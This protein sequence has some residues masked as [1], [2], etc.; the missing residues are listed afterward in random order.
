MPSCHSPPAADSGAPSNQVPVCTISFRL[1]ASPAVQLAVKYEWLQSAEHR[2]NGCGSVQKI[3]IAE[4]V[5]EQSFR[6]Q[7]HVLEQAWVPRDHRIQRI[8]FVDNGA[9][10]D[11]AS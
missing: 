2:R 7:M 11:R 9:S 1:F 8:L 4:A 3:A 6:Q 10:A 5:D